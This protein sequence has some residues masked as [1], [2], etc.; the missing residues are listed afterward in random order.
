MNYT[1]LVLENGGPAVR[2]TLNR[3]DVHNAFDETLIAELTDCFARLNDDPAARVIVLAGAGASFCAGADLGWMGRMAGYTRDENRADAQALQRMFAAIAHC[4]KVT[5]ARVHGAAIGG[6]AGL[7]A[8][9]DIA[10]A[11]HEATFA[12]SEV[13]L[14]LVPAVIAPYVMEK[15]GAGAARALFLTGERFPAQEALRLGLVQRVVP[16]DELDATIADTIA[17]ARQAGPNAVATAKQL[18]RDI[19]GKTPDEAAAITVECIADVR[20]GREAQEGIRS[21][22]EKR[23][24]SFAT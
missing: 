15:I 6:G 17:L 5:I 19:A 24:P 22:L 20:V 23:K 1:C 16:T 14:G 3:P 9:C 10:V 4:S 18:L 2:V 21:F 12:L 7:A 8:V 11:A 13:R